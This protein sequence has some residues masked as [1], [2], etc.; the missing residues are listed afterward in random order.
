MVL[1]DAEVDW[2]LSSK[3]PRWWKPSRSGSPPCCVTVTVEVFVTVGVVVCASAGD[4]GL[5][6]EKSDFATE[7][8]PTTIETMPN[9]R[10]AL[11]RFLRVMLR[12]SE[13]APFGGAFSFSTRRLLP[14]PWFS[15]LIQ[16]T[17]VHV[18][19]CRAQR[20]REKGVVGAMHRQSLTFSASSLSFR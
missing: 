11:S 13:R 1:V 5:A 15:P 14:R 19:G 2:L 7:A 17:D 4:G 6:G 20:R 9:V 18:L 3:R 12:S 8:T 16:P 10:P